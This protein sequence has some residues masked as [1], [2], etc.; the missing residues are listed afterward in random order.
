[1][2]F[3][4][5]RNKI[6]IESSL[7][8]KEMNVTVYCGANAGKE[9]RFREA[10]IL[11]GKWIGEHHHTLVYGGSSVG[12]MRVVADTVLEKGS[13]VIGVVPTFL[14][15]REPVHPNLTQLIWVEDMSERKRRM[16]SLGHLFI[17]LPGGPGTLEEITEVIS[18]AR[19]GKNDY[20][21]VLWNEDGYFA[22]LAAMYD[23]MVEEEFLS[24][25][26][27]AKIFFTSSLTELEEIIATY[28]PPAFRTYQ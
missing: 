9:E 16:A 3:L 14:T 13:D 19:I 11:I 20:P 6:K 27:R 10:A 26:D 4:A 5:K 24:P 18:W 2:Q 15:K 12:L 28:Q 1:L 21:C 22:P 25:E 17:A 7:E 23:K 8:V